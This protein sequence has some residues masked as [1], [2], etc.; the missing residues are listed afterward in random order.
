MITEEQAEKLRPLHGH[1]VVK[2]P[3]IPPFLKLSNGLEVPKE[4]AVVGRVWRIATC[5][6]IG[7][8]IPT[9]GGSIAHEIKVGD[10]LLVGHMFGDIVV[11]GK[12][13]KHTYRVLS[14]HPTCQIE[15]ILPDDID[16]FEWVNM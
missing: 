15:M 10:K 16:E 4:I 7:P 11:D 8:G 13:E 3:P 9:N 2:F 14:V 5:V 1:I 12:V 6:A